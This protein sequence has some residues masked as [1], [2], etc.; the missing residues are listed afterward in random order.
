MDFVQP[1]IDQAKPAAQEAIRTIK[2]T[3]LALQH[4]LKINPY[5]NLILQSYTKVID[6]I[7]KYDW[8]SVDWKHMVLIF[9]LVTFAFELFLE[10][11]QRIALGKKSLPKDLK[12]VIDEAV[13][14]KSA[15]YNID[16]WN[17]NLFSSF[18]STGQVVA[19]IHYNF[20]PYA[21]NQSSQIFTDYGFKAP[22]EVHQ[23]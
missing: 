3:L 22:S 18:Y 10:L 23:V 15:S 9:T 11:R 14:K 17:F 1:I 19:A 21:W 12:G 5:A 6:S 20:F 16:K 8:D 4:Q 13:F 7:K 2:Y